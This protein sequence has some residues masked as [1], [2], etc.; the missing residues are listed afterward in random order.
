MAPTDICKKN[1]Q[2]ELDMYLKDINWKRR[3]R[4]VTVHIYL[5]NF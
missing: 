1:A 2:Q 5:D 3:G 4:E